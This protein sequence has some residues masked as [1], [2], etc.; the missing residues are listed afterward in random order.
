M[1]II[2]LINTSTSTH[3]HQHIMINTHHDQQHNSSSSSS[4]SSS[5]HHDHHII[6][7]N[8]PLLRLH[9]YRWSVHPCT[10]THV[11]QLMACLAVAWVYA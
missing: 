11:A 4:S 1:I 3:Q 8:S 5:H 6:M 7:I 9:S 10:S 2:V